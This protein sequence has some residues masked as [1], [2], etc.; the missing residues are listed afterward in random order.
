MI[1]RLLLSATPAPSPGAGGDTALN[2][3]VD[4][5]G[6]ISIKR[7]GWSD[8]APAFFGMSVGKDDLLRLDGTSQATI[9]CSDLTLAKAAGCLRCLN[10][11]R[12]ACRRERRSS[13]RRIPHCAGL[14]S[15]TQRCTKSPCAGPT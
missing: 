4:V 15:Q 13:F 5:Q 3:V 9:V 11:T 2:L 1:S 12:A 6:N 7:L 8:Y 14:R 10:E